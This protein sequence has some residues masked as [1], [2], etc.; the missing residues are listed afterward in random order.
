[1][2]NIAFTSGTQMEIKNVYKVEGPNAM[3]KVQ[4]AMKSPNDNAD[5]VLFNKGDELHVAVGKGILTDHDKN[6]RMGVE[7]A[8]TFNFD[9]EKYEAIQV[10]DKINTSKEFNKENAWEAFNPGISVGAPATGAFLGMLIGSIG[11]PTGA[12]IG[13]IAGAV[14]M[15]GAVVTAYLVDKHNANKVKSPDMDYLVQ[16]GTAKVVK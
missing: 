8:V 14:A 2:S 10:K 4:A 5:Y 15:E 9:G 13:A 7:K 1:M 16:Q 12:K 3:Q 11:G 6:V